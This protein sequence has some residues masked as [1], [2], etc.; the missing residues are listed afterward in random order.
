[1]VHYYLREH[2][3]QYKNDQIIWKNNQNRNFEK[4]SGLHVESKIIR[5]AKKNRS[6]G[7]R[8]YQIEFDHSWFDHDNNTC[9]P[10]SYT[11]LDVYKRQRCF[12]V[13]ILKK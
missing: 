1:M 10:V 7:S 9:Y 8:S 6:D 12:W 13:E 3:Y 5:E 4:I 11:H 2:F